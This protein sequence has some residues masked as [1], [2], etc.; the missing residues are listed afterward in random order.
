VLKLSVPCFGRVVEL[1]LW[2]E[3]AVLRCNAREARGELAGLRKLCVELGLAPKEYLA[4]KIE[5]LRR[6]L[7]V[8]EPPLPLELAEFAHE[9]SPSE[10]LDLVKGLPRGDLGLLLLC[11]LAQRDGHLSERDLKD[12][13]E[14]VRKIPAHMRASYAA[15][16]LEEWGLL[17]LVLLKAG[18]GGA[19]GYCAVP[20]ERTLLE[21]SEWEGVASKFFLSALSKE[22]VSYVRNCP[23]VLATEEVRE[24]D[25][26]PWHLLN[27]GGWA[28]DLRDLSLVP[29]SLCGYWFT[30]RLDLGLSEAELKALVESVK[31]GEY[32]IESNRVYA[33]WRKHFSE[34]DWGRVC[35]ALGTLL[36]P[37]RFRLILVIVGPKGAGKSSFLLA[38]TKGVE[39]LV[40]RV[41][42]SSLAEGGFSLQPLLGKWA[43]AYSENVSPI[44]RNP[45]IINNLVGESDWVHVKRKYKVAVWARSLKCMVFACN[46]LP[47]VKTWSGGDLEAL[48]DR[49]SP[50]FM[51]PPEG[52]VPV[53]G[54]AESVSKAESFAFLLWCRKQLEERG[55]EVRKASSEEVRRL[56][57]ESENPVYRFIAECCVKRG[58]V[59]VERKKLYEAYKRWCAEQGVTAKLGPANFYSELR[60][61][62]FEDREVRGTWYFY[63]LNLIEEEA[64]RERER[65]VVES[66]Q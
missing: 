35:D 45:S 33:L 11:E 14:A 26:N 19:E 10:R 60:S 40:A 22:V 55:W 34:E 66:F 61:M 58:G 54:I 15:K 9:L 17:K 6:G 25:L 48:A 7:K 1:E 36:S 63:G 27:L 5:A 24:E 65:W 32:N 42:L 51:E 39:E 43:N 29:S 2:G 8:P 20:G 13:K 62:G 21:L 64:E 56:L 38:A 52:F 30:Y 12:L 31:R 37:H 59:R 46:A 3:H 50:V 57:V 28:L 18:E 53:R 41:P 44:L 16:L 23:A 49:L 4:L 47:A